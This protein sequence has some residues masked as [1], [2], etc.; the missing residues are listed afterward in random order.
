MLKTEEC[1]LKSAAE[2][3]TCG[4]TELYGLAGAWLGVRACCRCLVWA[5]VI[6]VS[7]SVSVDGGGGGQGCV[8]NNVV[9][10]VVD[11]VVSEVLM[12]IEKV[13][14]GLDWQLD[15]E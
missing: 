1:K 9:A 2:G 4:S 6:L 14:D 12:S 7:V 10:V 11:T 13:E 5:F 8:C 15:R 3:E